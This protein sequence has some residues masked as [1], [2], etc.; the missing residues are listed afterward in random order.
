MSSLAYSVLPNASSQ[1]E[2]YPGESSEQRGSQGQLWAPPEWACQG[3][4]CVGRHVETYCRWQTLTDTSTSTRTS[5]LHNSVG[6]SSALPAVDGGSVEG[7]E[8][9]VSMSTTV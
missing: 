6:Q 4:T 7:V 3:P 8:G 2:V 5:I 9:G 1:N